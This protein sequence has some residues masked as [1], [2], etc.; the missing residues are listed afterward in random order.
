MHATIPPT[1]PILV[2]LDYNLPFLT[3]HFLYLLQDSRRDKSKIPRDELKL[4]LCLPRS[5]SEKEIE[6][7]LNE[8][9]DFLNDLQPN[10]TSYQIRITE[11][12]TN[13]D[14]EP[15]TAGEISFW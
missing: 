5:C 11:P 15:F 8:Y 7:S 10:H 4:G 3:M 9:L 13:D 12:C 1:C 14:F 6:T 2:D